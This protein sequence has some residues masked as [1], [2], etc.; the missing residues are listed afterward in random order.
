MVNGV[1]IP[2]TPE[3]EAARDIEE[4]AAMAN[5]LLDSRNSISSL[6]A[7]T[8]KNKIKQA[9]G[10]EDDDELLLLMA[11][12]PQ[13]IK[14]RIDRVRTRIATKRAEIATMTQAQLDAVDVEADID[15]S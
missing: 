12:A 10:V 11:T 9:A 5:R 6:L 15:W 7:T 14:D 4:A 1:S 2:F 3:E 13:G 8:L